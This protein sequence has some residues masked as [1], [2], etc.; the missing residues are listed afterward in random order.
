MIT[1]NQAKAAGAVLVTFTV[2]EDAVNG[3]TVCVV[4]DFNG[5]NPLRTPLD[6]QGARYTATVLLDPGRR[7]RFRYLCEDGQWFND[8]AADAYEPNEH[9][10][11]DG[12][13]DLTAR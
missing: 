7:Y 11:N 1:R 2:A 13:I 9:G 8:E 10:G 6:K 3:R 5:W 4:G 12:V